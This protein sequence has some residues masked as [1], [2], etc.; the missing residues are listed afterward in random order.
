MN[1]YK[2][3]RRSG[4]LPY[5]GFAAVWSRQSIFGGRG[6]LNTALWRW[7][8]LHVK[9]G[10]DAIGPCPF[11][12]G[13][14]RSAQNAAFHFPFVGACLANCLGQVSGHP[15]LIVAVVKAVVGSEH[16]D[17]AL[18]AVQN[19]LLVEDRKAVDGAG[20]G[21]RR[22]V[23]IDH[24]IEE[25]GHIHRVESFVE[26]NRLDINVHGDDVGSAAAYAH[27]LVDNPLVAFGE[28][29][30]KI[31]QAVFVRA[32]IVNSAGINA[33]C[34]FEVSAVEAIACL[35]PVISHNESSCLCIEAVTSISVYVS[36]RFASLKCARF[37]REKTS[38]RR[39]P[40]P[41]PPLKAGQHMETFFGGIPA[42]ALFCRF[43]ST[44]RLCPGKK[45]VRLLPKKV[46]LFSFFDFG[47][48][49]A[50]KNAFAFEGKL[51]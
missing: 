1:A 44:P 30:P 26:R 49:P 3:R 34:L 9:K 50:G 14:G 41:L 28:V 21:R 7:L 20:M 45:K 23:H 5:S 10:R 15:V 47:C 19:H 42:T 27:S 33:D 25:E 35:K 51:R 37:E 38:S 16:L 8:R 31:F 40:S 17:R 22:S 11:S 12:S 29:Y 48:R 13:W 4:S 18:T 6:C 32:G 2:A 46:T 43:P 24:H 39:K 36:A